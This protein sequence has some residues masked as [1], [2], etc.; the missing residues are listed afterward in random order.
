MIIKCMDGSH[1]EIRGD[2]LVAMRLDGLSLHRAMLDGQDL[3]RASLV[4]ADLRGAFISDANLDD[5]VL[6]EASLICAFLVRTTLRRTV[7]D[8]GR[9]IGCI[10]DDADLTDASLLGVDIG[11]ASFSKARLH[12]ANLL[13][14][15]IEMASFA[16]AT[17][18]VHTRWPEGFDPIAAGAIL[19]S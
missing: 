9:A 12:G 6:H 19:E 1:V 10:F 7:L 2:G 18:D 14:Q 3:Q 13:C 11:H 17:Y 16:G 4:K 15:R 8:G 5:A